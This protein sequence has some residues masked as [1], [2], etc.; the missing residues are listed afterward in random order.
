[1]AK[2]PQKMEVKE[3][4]R[5]LVNSEIPSIQAVA[6]EMSDWVKQLEEHTSKLQ[7]CANQIESLSKEDAVDAQQKANLDDF[8][9]QL[10]KTLAKL[11]KRPELS[12]ETKLEISKASTLIPETLKPKAKEVAGVRVQ[13]EFLPK[14][15]WSDDEAKLKRPL[16]TTPEGFVVR[17]TRN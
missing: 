15:T 16:Y 17:K 2:K 1:M 9:K 8:I 4:I 14:T 5:S 11:R 6:K 10:E 7:E 3:L 12:E 13:A